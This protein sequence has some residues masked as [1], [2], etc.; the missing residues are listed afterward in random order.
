[1]VTPPLP[2]KEF[3]AGKRVLL[4]GHTGFK[5]S[6]TALW[7]SMLGAEVTGYALVPET[8]PSLFERLSPMPRLTSVIGD[9]RDEALLRR[10]ISQVRP[11]LVL[12]M[13]A[14]A[15]VRRSYRNPVETFAVNALGTALLLDLLRGLPD[16]SA[17]LIVTT[18]KVYRNS[19]QGRPFVEE[20]PLGGEDPYSA[21]KAA[22]ELVTASWAASYF[23]DTPIASARAGNVIGGG[24]WS[25]DRLI[26]DQWRAVQA[27]TALVL[28][29]PLATRPWQHVLDPV[30]GYLV[31]LEQLSNGA[32]LPRALNFGP[33]AEETMTVETVA[34]GML[35]ALGS[36]HSWMLATGAQP[37]EMKFLSLNASLA[38]RTLGWRPRLT[39]ADTL[40][41]TSSWYRAFDAGRDMLR[42]TQHQI[43]QYRYLAIDEGLR[44]AV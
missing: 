33:A 29:N 22:A 2:S 1:M 37:R 7:L 16:L 12:H 30:C 23:T 28:R 41:W 21:S 5:G 14:Q 19:D 31:Y 11:Q 27:D 20:D 15:L 8:T 10:T 43:E 42:L 13:A 35:R 3:W 39:M 9:L 44:H 25:E 6:W 36:R 40:T 34:D 26:P 24:D 38:A 17:V 18:D 32:Q 4:T